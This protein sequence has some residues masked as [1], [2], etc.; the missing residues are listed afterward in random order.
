MTNIDC[1]VL[2]LSWL[3]VVIFSAKLIRLNARYEKRDFRLGSQFDMI[4]RDKIDTCNAVLCFAFIASVFSAYKVDYRILGIHI[5]V[6]NPFV[7]VAIYF[8]L[9][10]LVWR[11]V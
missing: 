9:K 10:R 2:A 4:L 1:W 5:F 7:H 11:G 3:L 6:I 8:G